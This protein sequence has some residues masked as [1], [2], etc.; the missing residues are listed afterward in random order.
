MKATFLTYLIACPMAML[1]GFVD[2]V[3]GGGGLISLPGYMLAG[4]PVHFAIG[5]NK[6]SS[7]MGTAVATWRYAA[8]GMV[9]WKQAGGCV[10]G[11]LAGSALGAKIAL[12]LPADRFQL[13]MLVILPLTALYL[14]RHRDIAEEKTPYPYG[15]TACLALGIAFF[16]GIYDGFY[17]PGAGTFLILL[18]T[19]VAHMP[20]S[21]ANG[22]A[23]VINLATGVAALTVY[24]TGGKVLPV[25]GLTAGGFQHRRKLAGY[26]LF[27]PGRGQKRAAHYA[28]G[29]G[30][31]FCEGGLG[32]GDKITEDAQT[33]KSH[34]HG[35]FPC[36]WLFECNGGAEDEYELEHWI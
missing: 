14:M 24:L 3:A 21:D 5:T 26:P 1:A 32:A 17:G 25:L 8:A 22:T 33:K 34:P 31:L 12:L 29:A 2:A 4:L 19:A 11:A 18:L 27:P 23:K 6:L 28:A 30:R 10:A 16:V 9:P 36:G 15:K 35:L 13:M 20:L 7:A